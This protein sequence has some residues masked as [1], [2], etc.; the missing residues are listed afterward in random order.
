MV[1]PQSA[2]QMLLTAAPDDPTAGGVRAVMHDRACLSA[3]ALADI[4]HAEK[5]VESWIEVC[6]GEDVW[7]DSLIRIM[8]VLTTP[9][10]ERARCLLRFEGYWFPGED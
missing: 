1:D 2:K 4:E 7:V 3:W 8:D 5:L 9:P 6:K 10:A